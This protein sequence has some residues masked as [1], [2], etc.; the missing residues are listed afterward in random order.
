MRLNV[1]TDYALR[2]LM[3]LAVNHDRLCT[4]REISEHYG[5][6]NNHMIKVA[7][8]SGKAGF[9]TTVRGRSGG[10]TLKMA[11]EQIV[12]GDV[13]R[14]IEA[15]LAVVECFQCGINS[16]CLIS[17]SC[18]LK[19]ILREALAAFTAVLDRYTI[20]DLVRGNDG[21]KTLLFRE[22]A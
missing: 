2:Q 18:K 21:L 3:Y 5:I 4:I 22:V 16:K 14:Q 10:L 13:V 11:A 20:A 15:D 1:Q 7:Y 17:P 6:S 9:I 19:A 8:L 12:I